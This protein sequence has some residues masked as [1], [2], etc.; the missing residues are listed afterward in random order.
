MRISVVGIGLF[1]LFS[2][3]IIQFH[4]LQIIEHD[5]WL[6]LAKGQH[7]L[8]VTERASRGRFFS[9]TA[10]KPGHPAQSQ[11]FVIDVP[12]FHLFADPLVIPAP[13]RSEIVRTLTKH[14]DTSKEKLQ[15]HLGKK[16]RSRGELGRVS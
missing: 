4:R 11:A 2:L 15:S 6:A 10:L 16:S 7:E 13:C 12:K 14:L 5:R 3:L 8:V 9:N 1:T